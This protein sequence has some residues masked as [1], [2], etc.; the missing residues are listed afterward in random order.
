M[1][2]KVGLVQG[3]AGDRLH[4][5]LE[6]VEGEGRA[7]E[8]EGHGAIL[9][10]AA[11]PTQPRGQD[12]P[13]VGGH[14]RAGGGGQSAW[15]CGRRPRCGALSRPRP[16]PPAPPR[17]AVRSGRARAPR[18]SARRPGAN[19]ACA[20]ARRRAPRAPGAAAGP[21]AELGF[22]G[23]QGVGAA[24]APVLPREEARP[25]RPG[26]ALEFASAGRGQGEIAHRDHPLLA[27][28]GAVAQVGQGRVA[29][30]VAE[31]V[32]LLDIAELEAG[33]G[34]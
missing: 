34:R 14:G 5:A 16:R 15:P 30:L 12:A 20:R 24:G 25:G 7:Q 23:A 31:G 8:L 29:A 2:R 33:S 27:G 32:E 3:Q 4:R 1:R 21:G 6:V 18:S 10:L 11:Q 13:V 17:R 22:K 19:S 26:R 28:R 9:E